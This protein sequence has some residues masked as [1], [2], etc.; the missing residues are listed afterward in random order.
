MVS[1]IVYQY[2]LSADNHDAITFEKAAIA[3]A[4]FSG[5]TEIIVAAKKDIN[6]L[7]KSNYSTLFSHYLSGITLCY[8]VR[9]FQYLDQIFE[10]SRKAET[11]TRRENFYYH[12][13]LFI[14]DLLSRRYKSLINKPEVNLSQDDMT[15]LSRTRIELA[16]V[17]YTLAESQF[18]GNEKGYLAIFRSLTEIKS[19]TSLVMQELARKEN[20]AKNTNL[21]TG[22]I[23][24]FNFCDRNSTNY[25]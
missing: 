25:E 2:P 17:I 22:K 24:Q 5:N 15:E 13:R 14:L 12:G 1:N 19:L 20:Q 9:I 11:E 7:Y 18:P 3:L 16:E 21:P 6:Q 23:L 8:Y 4:C 10:N